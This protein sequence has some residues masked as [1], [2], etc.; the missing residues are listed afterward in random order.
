MHFNAV[1]MGL[2]LYEFLFSS[3]DEYDLS[4]SHSCLFTLAKKGSWFPL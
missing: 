1:G 2:K 4:V 3:L